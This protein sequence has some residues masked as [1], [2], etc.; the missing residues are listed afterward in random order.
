LRPSNYTQ[1][2]IKEK[3]VRSQSHLEDLTGQIWGSRNHQVTGKGFGQGVW[4]PQPQ[5]P[6]KNAP[7]KKN[8]IRS[9]QEQRGWR[10]PGRRPPGAGTGGTKSLFKSAID[11]GQVQASLGKRELFT[12][13]C[14]KKTSRI[15]E[16]NSKKRDMAN[17]TPAEDQRK[18][19]RRPQ[20]VEEAKKSLEKQPT[21][22]LM[23]L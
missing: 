8:K 16:G 9:G 5:N 17:L 6:K 13:E 12:R 7:K 11:G 23:R 21:Q 1:K 14:V 2:R 18:C 10:W 20:A 4:A 15:E 19:R 22:T 3:D